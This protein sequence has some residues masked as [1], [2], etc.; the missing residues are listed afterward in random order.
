MELCHVIVDC[1]I[2][3][4]VFRQKLQ[5]DPFFPIKYLID[6]VKSNIQWRLRLSD[7]LFT[8]RDWVASPHCNSD[9]PLR[10]S[11]LLSWS[12]HADWKPYRLPTGLEH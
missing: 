3:N 8:D 1:G 2:S 9:I 12:P 7:G 11:Q 4:L 10:I 6:D 5:G